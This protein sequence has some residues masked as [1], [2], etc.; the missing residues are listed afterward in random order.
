MEGRAWGNLL[1]D[2][3]PAKGRTRWSFA[4]PSRQ[5]GD[6]KMFTLLLPS[7]RPGPCAPSFGESCGGLAFL[8][9]PRLAGGFSHVHAFG[10]LPCSTRKSVSP[11]S[12]EILFQLL[13]TQ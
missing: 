5:G 9:P 10:D 1:R 7:L 2:P 3:L 13:G 6:L 12:S 4:V 8:P 11:T